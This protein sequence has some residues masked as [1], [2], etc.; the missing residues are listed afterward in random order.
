MISHMDMI[1][2]RQISRYIKQSG[3]A[4]S[5]SIAFRNTDEN[6]IEISS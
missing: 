2:A 3:L 5:R 1:K 6:Q 4:S